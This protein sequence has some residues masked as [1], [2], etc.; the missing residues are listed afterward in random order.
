MANAQFFDF[1]SR[2]SNGGFAS[3]QEQ[4]FNVFGLGSIG[5]ATVTAKK[6]KYIIEDSFTL[7]DG[8]VVNTKYTIKGN[9]N[10]SKPFSK[11]KVK[12]VEVELD[13]PFGVTKSKYT[14]FNVK[15]DQFIDPERDL[16]K[17]VF[18]GNDTLTGNPG[19][20]TVLTGFRG[21]DILNIK[22][23]NQAFGG[24]GA[25]I[26]ALSKDT[27]FAII[28]DFNPNK[29]FITVSDDDISNYILDTQFGNTVVV[30]V[31]TGDI[32]ASVNSFSDPDLLGQPLSVL[33]GDTPDSFT[34]DSFF[35]NNLG[36][37]GGDTGSETLLRFL[38][39]I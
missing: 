33:A 22:S 8:S 9:L 18:S 27:R 38:T 34:F 24:G 14:G 17:Q 3:A 7:F 15:F 21:D 2:S 35:A 11:R 28:F 4:F 13:A 1:Y 5:D 12:S 26:F 20:A 23:Q 10:T 36:G 25:D 29:D 31:N 37:S 30:N 19:E 6:N 32:L 16:F 39:N